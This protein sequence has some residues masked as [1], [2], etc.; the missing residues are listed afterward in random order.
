M[1]LTKV[2][3]DAEFAHSSDP[4]A[5]LGYLYGMPSDRKF[6]LYCL[7]ILRS[8]ARHFSH[9]LIERGLE[10]AALAAEQPVSKARCL[11]AAQLIESW[12]ESR[13]RT[14]EDFPLYV[15]ANLLV[16]YLYTIDNDHSF[17]GCWFQAAWRATIS[18]CHACAASR[19]GLFAR[20]TIDF[21]AIID[22]CKGRTYDAF[23]FSCYCNDP[24]PIAELLRELFSPSPL[25]PPDIPSSWLSW[26]NGTVRAIA[27]YYYE[28]DC[29]RDLSILADALVDADCN[30][31]AI[32]EHCHR[33]GGH[34]QGCWVLD[35]LL[36]KE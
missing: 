21:D 2:D 3:S 13:P 24:R 1:L 30:N 22:A 12:Q 7:A 29:Y 17:W 35:L 11:D 5:M 20:W 27:R 26:N 31:I 34:V 8:Q 32:L 6:K 19:S 33:K 9:E 4:L 14:H 28:A 23:D 15:F 16:D 25:Y 36:G 10:I 18:A